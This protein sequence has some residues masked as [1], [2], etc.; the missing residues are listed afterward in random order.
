MLPTY[1]HST[2]TKYWL[3]DLYGNTQFKPTLTEADSGYSRSVP[4]PALPDGLLF[5]PTKQSQRGKLIV[6]HQYS[7]LLAHLTDLPVNFS[8]AV[9]YERHFFIVLRL[10]S[11]N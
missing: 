2:A 3:V 5:D 7:L 6:T 1:K 11:R 4:C 10:Y 9:S 8:R